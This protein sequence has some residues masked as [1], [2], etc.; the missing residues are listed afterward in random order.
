MITLATAAYAQ[1]EV[2]AYRFTAITTSKMIKFRVPNRIMSASS[3][4]KSDPHVAITYATPSAD[5]W[6]PN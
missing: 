2:K 6:L 3:E 1:S 5:D 4:K